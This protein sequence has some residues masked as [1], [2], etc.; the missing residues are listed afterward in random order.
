MHVIKPTFV[1]MT[2]MQLPPDRLQGWI[3]ST[4]ALLNF[5]SAKGKLNPAST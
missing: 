5:A 4:L 2:T 1:T 3:S